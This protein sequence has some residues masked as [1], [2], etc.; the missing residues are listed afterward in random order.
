MS[1]CIDTRTFTF[2]FCVDMCIVLLS[3]YIY[4]QG[5]EREREKENKRECVVLSL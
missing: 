5:G 2:Y 3:T 1:L 4:I